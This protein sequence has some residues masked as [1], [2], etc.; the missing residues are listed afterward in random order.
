MRDL[1][2]ESGRFD[3]VIDFGTC[4]HASDTMEGRRAALSEVS[5][6]LRDGGL[7]VHETRVA[8]RLAHPVRSFG[9]TLPWRDVPELAPD[10]SAGSGLAQGCPP[11]DGARR[12]FRSHSPPMPMPIR[13]VLVP[14]LAL[15][16][17]APLG[18]Q[19]AVP[20]PAFDPSSIDRK[21]GACQDF[22]MFANNGWI[23]RNPIPPAYSS[24]G[25]FNELTERNTQVLKGILD[26]A[27]AQVATTT[28][29]VARKLGTFYATCMDSTAAERAG[30][31][32]IADVLQRIDGIADRAQLQDELAR[33]HSLGYGGGFG[34]GS[35]SDPRDARVTIAY[36]TQGGLGLPDRD[37]YLRTDVDAQSIRGALSRSIARMFELAGDSAVAAAA[38]AARVLDL[39]TALAKAQL[40]RVA[41]R[42]PNTRYHRQSVAEAT[43]VHRHRL[44]ALPRGDGARRP[45]V[46]HDQRAPVL[47]RRGQRARHASA[48]RLEVVSAVDGAMAQRIA[49]R[50]AV[51]RRVVQ[52]RVDADRRTPAAAEVA[53]MPRRDRSDAGRRARP[54]VRED[55]VHAG[56]EGEDARV[57]QS[58]RDVLRDRITRADWMSQATREQA[59]AKLA[60][61]N[62]KIGYPDP[63]RTTRRCEVLSDSYAANIAARAP[64]R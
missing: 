33:M 57:V 6:V 27:A 31:D 35:T 34:F 61:F 43:R 18:A 12:R 26:R 59:L 53:P 19:S 56:G 22:F 11:R 64:I 51:R 13:R 4:Y 8:Q 5:R 39:E 28:D 17:A 63:G 14:F 30:I 3:L 15:L 44:G 45:P 40:S 37:Y 49:A 52:A 55:R 42:D 29:P 24:W 41:L 58:L 38:R 32:P 9:R 16:L 23:E 47:Q 7:F 2:F 46:D 60:S 50:R 10:R 62:Q 25:A 1:P 21:F 48:R 36:A 54:R 20:I